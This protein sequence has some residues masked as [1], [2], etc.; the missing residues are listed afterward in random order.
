MRG[1]SYNDTFSV[2]EAA[3]LIRSTCG[4]L[5]VQMAD[6]ISEFLDDNRRDEKIEDIIT[7]LSEFPEKLKDYGFRHELSV[8]P[9]KARKKTPCNNL[10]CF[11]LGETKL[12]SVF[13]KIDKATDD[14]KDVSGLKNV[15]LFTDKWNEK[16]F[17]KY[18]EVFLEKAKDNDI[19]FVFYM[20]SE[21]GLTQI[22]F[23]PNVRYTFDG[24]EEAK[25]ERLKIKNVHK[26]REEVIY[27]YSLSLH[28]SDSWKPMDGYEYEFY[29]E[30]F[31]WVEIPYSGETKHGSFSK[32]ALDTFLRSIYHIFNESD[33]NFA[34][35]NYASDGTVY[36]LKI[37]GE[38]KLWHF[39]DLEN[40]DTPRGRLGH[41]VLR[42][43]S[44]CK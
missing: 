17:E 22:P 3:N 4:C 6:P 10:L 19:W 23:L 11:G 28:V 38:S 32:S 30:R 13:S 14:M 21:E 29:C 39:S 36:E 34:S 2:N 18:E 1:N 24:I 42:F 12:S 44:K 25:E 27:P 16:A 40:K 31:E 37:N 41:A 43:I 5:D 15:I 9:T 35:L 20:I 8:I 7:A 26:K 33:E